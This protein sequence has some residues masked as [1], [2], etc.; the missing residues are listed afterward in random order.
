MDYRDIRHLRR[1]SDEDLPEKKYLIGIVHRNNT[2]AKNPS[3]IDLRELGKA[4]GKK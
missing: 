1:V 3:D 4:Y 2:L